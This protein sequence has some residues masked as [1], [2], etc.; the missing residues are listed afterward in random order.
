MTFTN[1]VNLCSLNVN[2]INSREKRNRVIEWVTA[3]KSVISFLQE[4]HFDE[5]I[6]RDINSKTEYDAFCS[7]GTTASRGVAILI[8]N[9]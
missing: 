3:Q 1:T 9:H 7:H 5:I 8:K 4:T 2:G 6:E